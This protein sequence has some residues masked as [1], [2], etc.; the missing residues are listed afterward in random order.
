MR[1]LIIILLFPLTLSGQI[2]LDTLDQKYI[3]IEI[4]NKRK[5][6]I[7]YIDGLVIYQDNEIKHFDNAVDVLNWMDKRGYDFDCD[8]VGLVLFRRK[9]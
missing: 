7:G 6:S 5:Y 3:A 2:D 8:C 1:Y 9:E 4:Y